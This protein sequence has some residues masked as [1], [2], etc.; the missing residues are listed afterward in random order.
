MS[1]VTA[2]ALRRP[3]T[4]HSESSDCG[5][6]LEHPRP[7]RVAAAYTEDT[8]WRVDGEIK[9]HGDAAQEQ[10]L[11][12]EAEGVQFRGK[13]VAMDGFEHKM[14]PWETL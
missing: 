7:E 11:R 1:I 5:G 8:Q 14:R 6:S 13:R 10:R 9:L 4:R 3:G 12:L 2:P